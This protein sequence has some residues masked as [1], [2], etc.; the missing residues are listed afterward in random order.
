MYAFGLVF[1][2]VFYFAQNEGVTPDRYLLIDGD[3]TTENA[4]NSQW[5]MSLLTTIFF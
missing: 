4:G 1:L 3:N 5:C 2:F